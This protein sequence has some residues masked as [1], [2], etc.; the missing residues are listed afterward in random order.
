MREAIS[1]DTTLDAMVGKDVTELKAFVSDTTPE[2]VIDSDSLSANNAMRLLA[3]K[4][5][6]AVREIENE[7]SGY[8]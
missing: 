8:R 3:E 1:G 4:W 7:M 6:D 2:N 5:T